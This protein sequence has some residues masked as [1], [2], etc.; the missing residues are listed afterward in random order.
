MTETNMSTLKSLLENSMAIEQTRR[1]AAEKD[2]KKMSDSVDMSP[3][4]PQLLLTLIT[5]SVNQDGIRQAA[6]IFLKNLIHSHW[7][8]QKSD[9]PLTNEDR[10]CIKQSIIDVMLVVPRFV[11]RVLSQAIFLICE[12]DFPDQWKELI[13]ILVEKLESS[14]RATRMAALETIHSIF[15]RYRTEKGLTESIVSELV[16]INRR[17]ANPLLVTLENACRDREW[18]SVI[19]CTEIFHSLCFLDFGDEIEAALSRWMTCFLNSLCEPSPRITSTS[20]KC[21]LKESIISTLALFLGKYDEEFSPYLRPFVEI[22]WKVLQDDSISLDEGTTTAA[23][24][25]VCAAMKGIHRTNF[26]NVDM[27]RSICENVVV[28]NVMLSSSDLE[29]FATEPREYIQRDIEGNNSQTRRRAACDLAQTALS[30]TFSSIT[31][32]IFSECIH[33]LLASSGSSTTPQWLIRDAAL[34]LLMS[35]EGTVASSNS[36]L[37][38]Q[39]RLS[40]DIPIFFDTYIVPLICERCEVKNLQTSSL[41]LKADALKFLSTFRHGLSRK[42]LTDIFPALLYWVSQPH[43]VIATYAAHCIDRL[44]DYKSN[45]LRIQDVRPCLALTVEASHEFNGNLEFPK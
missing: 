23:L 21:S 18:D 15:L 37:M 38:T 4:L 44:L 42:V 41:I 6:A 26:Q 30:D 5:Q 1:V 33:T 24:D 10:S 39:T 14:E 25:F 35:I 17:V 9:H 32:N 45:K 34:T 36:S 29:M 3:G 20:F 7:D 16:E 40:C 19:S 43:E 12:M 8:E 27:L 28:K 13:P 11:R 22:V 2:L 31:K